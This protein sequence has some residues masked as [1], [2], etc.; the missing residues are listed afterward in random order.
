MKKQKAKHN[1]NDR[2]AL[3]IPAG[4]FLGL[5]FGFVYNKIPEGLFLG[6]GAG[7]VVYAI[8]QTLSRKK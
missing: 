6:L 4:I 2:G 3:F 1:K 8:V 5:G 7:F